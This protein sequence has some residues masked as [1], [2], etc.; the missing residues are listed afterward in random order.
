MVFSAEA[1]ADRIAA[2]GRGVRARLP[3]HQISARHARADRQPRAEP[4][5]DA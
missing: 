2:E 5:G 4:F 3:V 1:M